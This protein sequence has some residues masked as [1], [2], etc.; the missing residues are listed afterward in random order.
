MRF[1]RRP[2]ASAR[3]VL[4]PHLGVAGL[5][6]HDLGQLRVRQRLLLD[7]PAVEALDH[8]AQRARAL[9]FSSSV[10]DHGARGFEQRNA[11]L[12]R[13]IVQELD[14]GVA[15]AALRRVDDALE[16]EVVGRRVD[17]AEI[18][19][20]VADFGALVEP[21]AA[22]DAIGQAERDEAV[23]ELAH[24]V[25]RRAPGSPSLRAN[26]PCALELLDLLADRA[27]LF[28]AESQPPVTVTFSPGSSSVRS[29]LPSR[30]SLRAMRCE[31]AARICPVLR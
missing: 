19:Q 26:G 8:A 25:T 5:V 27:G 10:S 4:L 30:P 14:G 17:D 2:A 6:E 3:A 1:S 15:Q 18:G 31:A 16:G 22:D 24:L 11:A 12:A 29:V 7:A 28:L 20:R 21:R 23:F 13:V 9:G